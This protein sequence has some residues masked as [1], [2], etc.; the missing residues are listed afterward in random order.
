M[1]TS[2]LSGARRSRTILGLMVVVLT[3]TLIAACGSSKGSGANSN[4]AG[5]TVSQ[6]TSI[7]NTDLS[8][9]GMTSSQL[10]DLSSEL[11]VPPAWVDGARKEGK[12]IIQTDQHPDVTDQL[13][14]AFEERYPYIQADFVYG[15]TSDNR[16]TQA[17]TAF[18]QGKSITDIVGGITSTL[19]TFVTAGALVKVSDLPV[20]SDIPTSSKDSAG[21]W[22]GYATKFWG[23][24]YNTDKVK[25]ADLPKTWQDVIADPRFKQGDFGISDKPELFVYQLDAKYGAPF[26]QQFSKDLFALKPQLRSEGQGAVPQ[27]LANGTISLLMPAASYS[28]SQLAAQGAPVSWYTPQPPI[29]NPSD[30]EIMSNATNIDAARIFVNWEASTEGQVI[31]SEA[32]AISPVNDQLKTVTKLFPYPDQVT[33]RDWL[34]TPPDQKIA[35]AAEIDPIW[36][37]D[38]SK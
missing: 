20:W 37:A 2:R 18:K 34:Y 8:K 9:L 24:G 15:S 1:L 5:L 35:I 13:K 14:K 30:L 6:L 25:V 23:I 19:Q 28:I 22:I 38:W 29:S 10:G 17:L 16:S 4:A 21:Y 26:A 33:N 7:L 3:S 12:V 36:K 31:A 11:T 32:E 27:L